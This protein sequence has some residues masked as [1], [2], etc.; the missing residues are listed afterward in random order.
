MLLLAALLLRPP[1]PAPAAEPLPPAEAVR[2]ATTLG[3]E[4]ALT[5]A[6]DEGTA[7]TL[8]RQALGASAPVVE[9]WPMTST[10]PLRRSALDGVSLGSEWRVFGADEHA[11]CWVS[12]FAVEV[13]EGTDPDTAV[14]GSGAPCASP[15]F[16]ATLRCDGA[17]SLPEIAVPLAQAGAVSIGRPL[18]EAQASSGV[19]GH[20]AIDALHAEV[21]AESARLGQGAVSREVEA[22]GF[23]VGAQAVTLVTGRHFTGE[24]LD[25][26]GEDDIVSAWTALE[27]GGR[28]VAPRDS[29]GSEVSMLLDLEGDGAIEVLS[30]QH[31]VRTLSRED[32]TLIRRDHVSYCECGC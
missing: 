14:F 15:L 22:A 10:L 23:V 11:T 27:V 7:R 4:I 20:A 9:E 16:V 12:G 29:T 18:G 8:L 26:C 30:M 3:D 31:T 6:P 28:V 17:V 24:G 2:F 19:V 21:V 1:A 5:L 13:W 25:G 32:G